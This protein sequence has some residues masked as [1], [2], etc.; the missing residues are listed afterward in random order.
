MVLRPVL[1]RCR[2]CN[3]H[4][5][6]IQTS[7]EFPSTTWPLSGCGC[8][9]SRS[10]K[11]GQLRAPSP[12]YIFRCV[13]KHFQGYYERFGSAS[14][15][16]GSFWYHFNDSGK[17]EEILCF[18]NPASKSTQY[19]VYFFKLAFFNDVIEHA[20]SHML[21]DKDTFLKGF[22]CIRDF[23][24]F[25]NVHSGLFYGIRTCTTTI[26]VNND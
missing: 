14:L 11:R 8:G 13:C 9:C 25:F 24:N 1:N 15:L 3:L 6:E 17:L 16:S 20:S 22:T 18:A 7:C 4:Q 23:G 26:F 10:R 12:A 2:L 19:P 21:R 5:T